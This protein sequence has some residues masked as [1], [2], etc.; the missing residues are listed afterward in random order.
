MFTQCMLHNGKLS[1][2]VL[3]IHET[4]YCVQMFQLHDALGVSLLRQL[5]DWHQMLLSMEPIFLFL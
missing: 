4:F 2:T 3:A 1:D 5:Q